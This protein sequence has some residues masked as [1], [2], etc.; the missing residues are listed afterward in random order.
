MGIQ[1]PGPRGKETVG[2]RG[3]RGSQWELKKN[4]VSEELRGLYAG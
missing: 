1:G 2:L 4:E 3:D